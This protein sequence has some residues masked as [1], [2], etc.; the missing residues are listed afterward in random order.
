MDDQLAL[1]AEAY[2]YPTAKG[3]REPSVAPASPA[4]EDERGAFLL[5]FGKARTASATDAMLLAFRQSTF[6]TAGEFVGCRRNPPEVK[7]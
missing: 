5:S 2:A 7:G 4:F 1:G 3:F 6:E